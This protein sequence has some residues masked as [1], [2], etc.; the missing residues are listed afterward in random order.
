METSDRS[1]ASRRRAA[2]DGIKVCPHSSDVCNVVFHG[3]SIDGRLGWRA[4]R[5]AYHLPMSR[6]S[7][8]SAGSSIVG[9]MV[10]LRFC[11]A[12]LFARAV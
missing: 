8:R 1:V 9:G 4:V 10:V 12:L 5:C 6:E 7:V 3:V 11:P 2:R